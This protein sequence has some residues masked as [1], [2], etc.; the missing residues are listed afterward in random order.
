MKIVILGA[1]LFLALPAVAAAQSTTPTPPTVPPRV[2]P[3]PIPGLYP[4][5]LNGFDQS[6][7]E[8]ERLRRDGAG[9]RAQRRE[10]AERLA[11]LVNSGQCQAAHDAAI[12]E[13]DRV[14]AERIGNVCRPA[15]IAATPAS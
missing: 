8:M 9:T 10:R 4:P 2:R 11:A 7:V 13:R 12:Q 5:G 14:M 6:H 1:A 3:M 15:A